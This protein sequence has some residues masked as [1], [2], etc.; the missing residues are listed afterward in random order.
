MSLDHDIRAPTKIH[1]ELQES[2]QLPST[3]RPRKDH[4]SAVILGHHWMGSPELHDHGISIAQ[5]N[6]RAR[7]PEFLLTGLF[8]ISEVSFTPFPLCTPDQGWFSLC[9][10][11]EL[12]VRAF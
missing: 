11:H 12:S 9:R 4:D 8:R 1:P 5:G 3:F 6:R 7:I 10:D 2:N